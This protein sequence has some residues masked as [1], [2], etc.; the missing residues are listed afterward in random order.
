MLP[1]TKPMMF[2]RMSDKIMQHTLTALLMALLLVGC[3]PLPTSTPAVSPVPFATT[4]IVGRDHPSL[5]PAVAEEQARRRAALAT[6]PYILLREDLTAQLAAAQDLIVGDTRLQAYTRTSD[7]GRLLTE[8]MRVAPALPGDLAPPLLAQC[9]PQGCLRIIL[10]VY[11]TNTTVSAIV[12]QQMQLIDLHAL[13]GAQ[14]EIPERLANLAIQ[15]AINDSEV[16][17]AF[18]GLSP[19]EAMAMM[20]ATKTTLEASSCERSRHLCVAPVFT[21]GERALWTV[22]DLTEL[23]LVAA[24]TWTEQGQSARRRA[25]SEATLQDAALAP[26]CEQPGRVERDGWRF[27]YLLTSS[28]GLELRMISYQGRPLLNSIKLVDWHVGYEGSGAQRVGFSDAVGCP[29]FSAAA[30]IPYGPPRITDGPGAAFTLTISFRSPAWPQPCNYQYSFTAHFGADGRLKVAA[31]NEGRG[32]GIN[33]TYHPVWRIEAATPA[34]L[35]HRDGEATTR[36]LTEGQAEWR[37][38][39]GHAFQ[40]TAPAGTVQIRPDGGDAEFAYLYWS[41]VRPV[42]G[43]G[44]LATIGSCCALDARQGPEQFVGSELLEQQPVLW[45]VPRLTNRERVRCWADMRL[46]D[47]LLRPVIWPCSA[48]L[49][50][51]HGEP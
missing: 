33:G 47:G 37:P 35:S 11:A 14:P 31:A 26:L 16:A 43:Q 21:W 24:Q 18:D 8:V 20:S 40:L 48:G 1:V 50:I 10:Y 22:V 4:L 2:T 5:L 49:L 17:A 41:R 23:R 51:S 12:D 32:C 15:I 27:D 44:D 45:Y 36:L 9:S 46:E 29:V 42:E 38:G 13:V 3:A 19:T 34:T 28:D 6:A 39:D 7:G 25:V 30:V